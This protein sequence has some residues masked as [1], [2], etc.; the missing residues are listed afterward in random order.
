MKRAASISSTLTLG[1]GSS[2]KSTRASGSQILT[3]S[4]REQRFRISPRLPHDKEVAPASST[5]MYWSK[6]PVW[7]SVPTRGF[8][9][10]TVTLV[11]HVAWLFGGCDDTNSGRDIYCFDTETMQWMLLDAV[12]DLPPPSRA[13]STTLC[14]RRMVVFGGGQGSTYYS[15][16]Y[17]LDTMTRRWTRPHIAPGP[18][19]CARRAH[20]AVYYKG[21]V[22]VFG[23]GNGLMALND[24]WT[25]DVTGSGA[26]TAARPMRWESIETTGKK[27][28]PRGYHSANLINNVMVVVGG[29]DAKDFFTDVWC[30]NLDT[31]VW[32]LATQQQPSYKRLAHSSTQVGSYIFIFG[33]HNGQDYVSDLL[34]YNLVSLQYEPRT[35]AGKSP[36]NRGYHATV[37]AD[38]RLFLFGGYD[39]QHSFDDV[40]ILDLAAGAYLPQVTSFVMD[41]S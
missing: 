11:D 22:W 39:G 32:S 10:G 7:G 23:G 9:A 24:L 29:S 5:I 26:G 6:A 4:S 8:R 12:G 14:D 41:T 15:S 33:G 30:L 37:L 2:S 35:I 21:K 19:P 27:P 3:P 31:L 17:V 18:R 13:H 34:L 16:V 20:S 28:G 38:S 36:S 25:L 1:A 40:Y